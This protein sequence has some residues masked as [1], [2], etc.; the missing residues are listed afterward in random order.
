MIADAGDDPR[1]REERQRAAR[2]LLARPLLVAGDDPAALALVRR[3]RE[4]LAE[5]FAHLLGYRLT[6]RAG[7]ARLARRLHRAHRDRP[8]RVRPGSAQ[9]GPEDGWAPFTRRHYLMLALSLTALEAHHGRAQVLIGRLAD[10]VAATG[11]ELGVRVDF[12]RHAERRAFAEVLDHLGGLG[13]LV[14]RDGSSHGFVRR[15]ERIDEA[16]F[17]V[18]HPRLA[19]LK[20]TPV[21]LT[22]VREVDDVLAVPE[23]YPATETGERARRRHRL[24]RALVEDPVLYVEDLSEDERDTYRSQRHRLEPELEQ[25]TGLV[26]E[27]R[28][29]GSALVDPSRRLTDV[30]FP[31]RGLDSQLAVVGCERLRALALDRHTDAV[32]RADVLGALAGLRERY[33][34]PADAGLEERALALLERHDLVRSEDLVVRVM[35]ALARFAQP[36]VRSD[37]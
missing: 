18:E 24:A 7:H 31:T 20:A 36:A 21:A 5:R 17:D 10:E 14:Q 9:P 32:P 22:D 25:L 19:D 13:V 12:E 30:R 2:A 8:A 3:H 28:A 37:A 11:A 6:V 33:G 35:P 27:R 26:A 34:L 1:Q 29:E 4:W 15:D 23:D 16:L